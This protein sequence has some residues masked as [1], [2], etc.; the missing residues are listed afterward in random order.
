MSSRPSTNLIRR[1][2]RACS[3]TADLL[4]IPRG[5]WHVAT[6][7]DE[8]TLHLTVGVN[9]PNGADFLAWYVDRLKTS[10]DVRRDLPQFGCVSTSRVPCS[11][12]FAICFLGM[13]T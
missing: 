2:G 7:L 13:A 1:C 5:W 12:A 6:P 10:E 11:I 9:N 3:K 4:Y 8:P